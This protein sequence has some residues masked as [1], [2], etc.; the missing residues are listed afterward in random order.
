MTLLSPM[1]RY[2]ESTGS[3]LELRQFSGSNEDIDLYYDMFDA[4]R[5]FIAEYDADL[6]NSFHRIGEVAVQ[7]SPLH[8]KTRQHFEIREN[9]NFA[10]STSMLHRRDDTAEVT[11][12]LTEQRAGRGLAA[13]ACTLMINR[14]LATTGV[15]QF[16]ALIKPTNVA[17]QKT[18]QRVGFT[19]TKTF[20][21][22]LLY[23]LDARHFGRSPR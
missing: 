10:G 14:T 4:N 12:W 19:H 1:S 23:E 3:H 11:Y 16:D 13:H 21:D 20:E 22:D 18:I 15:R 5:D 17:S 9:G 2:I 6:A 7:L 8:A